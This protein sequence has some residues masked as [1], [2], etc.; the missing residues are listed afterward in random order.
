MI[1][2]HEFVGEIVE[3]G[4]NVNDFRPG[5]WSPAR[6]M[7]SAAL[8]QLPGGRRHLLPD[9]WN[10]RG[11]FGAF[12]STWPCPCPMSGSTARIDLD[13]AALFDPLGNAVHTALQYDLLG[14]DVLIT[15]LAL[16]G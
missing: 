14:E 11:Y 2:G 4:S 13:V 1:V 10:R 9:Q 15:G 5:S 12:A 6:V 16:S 7:W 8:P 3:V